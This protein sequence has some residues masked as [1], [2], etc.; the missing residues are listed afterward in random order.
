[1]ISIFSRVDYIA[2]G[3]WLKDQIKTILLFWSVPIL[4]MIILINSVCK[5]SMMMSNQKNWYVTLH[6]DD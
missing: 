2:V 5:M 6:L 3:I 4:Y 1:M